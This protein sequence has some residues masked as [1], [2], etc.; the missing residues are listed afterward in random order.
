MAAKDPL[1]VHLVQAHIRWHKPDTNLQ[2]FNG[3]MQ[4]I[5]ESDLI[6]LPEMW[7]TGFTMKAQ[8]YFQ[9]AD[10]AIES[11]CDW[12]LK[13]GAAVCGSLIVRN[14]EDYFNRFVFVSGGIV[15]GSYDKR[16]LFAYSGEDK[17]F[18]AG[19]EKLI[20]DYRGWRICPN[21]CYDLRF[22]VWSRNYEDYDILIYSANW[23][24]TRE[25]AWTSL[26][27]ARAIENQAYVLG[28]N[29]FGTD[30]WHNSYKGNSRAF[31]YDGE[32]LHV[33]K[34]GEALIPLTLEKEKLSQF[35]KDF[36]FLLQRDRVQSNWTVRYLTDSK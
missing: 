23:P 21:I 17:P 30:A 20:I 25:V 32:Q 16:H 36:P 9:Y 8:L 19:T 4:R 26:L 34:E 31:A 5:G 14:G 10:K 12:S 18:T 24:D 33:D 22:P 2:H 6:V 11:M 7:N 15:T 27:R 29:C 28:V 35:R 3:I 13:I 1:K